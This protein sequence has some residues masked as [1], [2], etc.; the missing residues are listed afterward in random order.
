MK[1]SFLVI[2]ILLNLQLIYAQNTYPWPSNGNI[3]IGTTNPQSRLHIVAGQISASS[4]NEL[5]GFTQLWSDNALIWKNGNVN[6]GIRFGSATDLSAGSWSEKMRIT[7]AGSVCVGCTSPITRFTVFGGGLSDGIWVAGSGTT[8]IALLNNTGQGSWNRLT[9]PGDNMVM[10][11]GSA[12]EH[13][14]AGGLVIGPWS[15]DYKGIRITS[16]GYVGIGTP[17]PQTKLA[18]NGDITSKKV[19][20]TVTGWPDY[21]F[22]PGY[23]LRPLTEVEQYIQQHQRLPEVPSAVEVKKNGL[24]LGDNQATLLKKI[25][26]LTLYL[27]EIKRENDQMK[28]DNDALKQRIEKLEMQ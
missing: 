8:N 23:H 7:D 10:W 1:K 9:Q 6:G 12:V 26:E 15:N 16:E 25:E 11:K 20:V 27:I 21:V 2:T 22:Q 28:K 14:N 3:G 13:A 24:D 4:D 19:M 5:S 17:S 18:V